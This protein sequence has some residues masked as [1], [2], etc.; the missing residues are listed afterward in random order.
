MCQYVDTVSFMANVVSAFPLRESFSLPEL[1][2]ARQHVEDA[3][4]QE[5]IVIE[6]TR[7][8]FLSTM[9]YYR[10]F[11]SKRDDMVSVSQK[12][13]DVLTEQ[14]V[15]EEFNFRLDCAVPK[16]IRASICEAFE[17]AGG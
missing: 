5:D 6:W 7:S 12:A 13:R 16:K 1:G 2:R 10:D 8:A 9:F 17:P 3:L 15:D 11:F 14:F 4:R